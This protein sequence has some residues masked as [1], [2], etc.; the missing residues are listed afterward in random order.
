MAIGNV[1]ALEAAVP[2]TTMEYAAAIGVRTRVEH[3]APVR[4]GYRGGDAAGRRRDDD[5]GIEIGE[6]TFGTV[7][8][9]VV[10]ARY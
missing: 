10:V 3:I 5:E 4:P 2:R 9:V 1:A 6:R 8:H 7:R